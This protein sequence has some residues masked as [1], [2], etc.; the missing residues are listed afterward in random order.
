MAERFNMNSEQFEAAIQIIE[1]RSFLQKNDNK[2]TLISSL[3]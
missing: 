2:S 3:C 1:S